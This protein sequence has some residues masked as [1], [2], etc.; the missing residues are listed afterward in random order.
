MQWLDLLKAGGG[1]LA[2]DI[3]FLNLEILQEFQRKQGKMTSKGCLKSKT[4]SNLLSLKYRLRNGSSQDQEIFSVV[5][6]LL[7]MQ[8]LLN[9]CLL[10]MGND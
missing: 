7:L 3:A 8:S 6:A 10:L 5:G 1:S 4:G 2:F 9:H